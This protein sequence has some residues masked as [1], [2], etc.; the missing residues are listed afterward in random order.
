MTDDCAPETPDAPHLAALPDFDLL[1]QHGESVRRSDLLGAP[2]F[3]VFYP[4]AFTPVCAG[5]LDQ[6][7]GA[8][9]ALG[10]RIVAVST[11]PQP[12][13]AAWQAQR[14]RPFDLLA[15]YWPHGEFAQACEA[16]DDLSGA[17]RRAALA[18]DAEGAVRA[19]IETASGQA[20]PLTWY[21]EWARQL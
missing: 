18:V 7:T 11:D 8:S 14:P 4:H 17:A 3:V 20:R 15:D 2:A 21:E 5:E 9:L 19:R 16:F 13:L 6:L 10:I 12:T 1:N